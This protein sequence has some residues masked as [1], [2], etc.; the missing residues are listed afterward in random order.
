MLTHVRFHLSHWLLSLKEELLFRTPITQVTPYLSIPSSLSP[1]NPTFFSSEGV[2]GIPV[3]PPISFGVPQRPGRESPSGLL[4]RFFFLA[5][6]PPLR[7]GPS[8]LTPSY[9]YAVTY[10]FYCTQT[11]FLQNYG[12]FLASQER[13]L[14]LVEQLLQSSY[15]FSQLIN[16]HFALSVLSLALIYSLGC[17]LLQDLERRPDLEQYTVL[18]LLRCPSKVTSLIPQ[19]RTV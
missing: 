7:K 16:V 4:G 5:W 12:A 2:L 17:G 1:Q 6:R 10:C 9:V 18:E 13:D 14:K 8:S 15:A 11:G 3:V 19:L